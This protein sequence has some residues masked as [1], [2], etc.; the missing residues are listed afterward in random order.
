[1][2]AGGLRPAAHER[3]VHLTR[4]RVAVRSSFV[5]VTLLA[6]MSAGAYGVAR[7]TV[8]GHLQERLDAAAQSPQFN[9]P[10]DV[11]GYVLVGGAPPL[12]LPAQTAPAVDPDRD[13]DR[14]ELAHDAR[15]GT[16]AIL[17]RAAAE[18]GPAL[19][20]LPAQDDVDALAAFLWVLVGLTVVG[21]LAALPA[22]YL[23]AGH[24]LRPLDEAVRQRTEFVALAS[25]RLRTPLSVIRTSAELALAGKALEPEEALS[26]I[27]DQTEDMEGLATR[28]ADMARAEAQPRSERPACDLAAV[29]AAVLQRLHL[30]AERCGVDLR[31]AAPTPVWAAAPTNDAVD[32][33]ATVL[34]NAVRYSPRAGA[35]TVR[36]ERSGRW[37]LT[38]VRDEGPGIDPADLPHIGTAFFQGR[39]VR[40]GFGLGLAITAAIADRL[41]GSLHVA[42]A[43]GDGTTVTIRLPL[44]RAA[45]R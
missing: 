16:L 18:G 3:L 12:V 41:G 45:S 30:A 17:R 20:A 8:Y 2:S 10:P 14:F 11:D 33:L 37:G 23:L 44:A 26:T 36:V 21:G 5:V 9:G 43:A 24:A 34:E 13:A 1:M 7:W 27:I 42:S 39:R 6:V 4:W 40:G 28:L 32:M 31:L 29:A 25:H 22:G 19:L 15:Y 38:E 35:V